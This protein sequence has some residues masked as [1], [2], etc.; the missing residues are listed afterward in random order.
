MKFNSLFF[1]GLNAM[2]ALGLLS[3]LFTCSP[4][5]DTR[6]TRILVFTKT[7]GFRH[8][9][10][11][12]GV[13]A[14]KKLGQENGF[15]AVH[16]E[17]SKYFN[18]DFLKTIS[19][20]MFLNTTGD[21]LDPA[22]K[23]A[24]Q[25]YIQA[26]GGFVGV[27]SA[28][29]TEYNWKWYGDMVGAYFL[30]HPE[31]Q[32]ARVIVEDREHISTKMLPEVW[33]R[34]D[35]WYDFKEVRF[36]LNRLLSLDESS[37]KGGKMGDD[38]PLAW[39]HEFDGGR[40]W[41]TAMGHTDETFSEPLFL[42][43]LLGGIRYAIGE[44]K[45]DYSKASAESYPDQ[46]RFVKTELAANLNEPMELDMLPDGRILFVERKGA[47]KMYD[48]A[49]EYL[50]TV[51][52]LRVFSGLEDGLLGIAIDPHYRENH[53]IY[54]MYSDPE[55]SVQNV[56]RFVFRDDT[57]H[58]ASEKVLL[59]V[60]TQRDEC[61]HSGGSLEFGPDGTLYISTGDNTNPFA[62]EGFSP[63]DERPGR[64]PWD[65]QRSSAN[66]NDLRGKILRIKPEADGTYS[67]PEGNLFEPGMPGARPEIFVMGCRNPF[68]ISVDQ[69]RGW[70]F[71]GDV[72]PD[73]GEDGP[74]RG[75]KGIDEINLAQG[76]GFWGWPYTRGDNQAYYA[77][78][79]AARRSGGKFDPRRLYN[80]S[81]FNTGM[82]ELP[83][84]QPSLIWY[85][86]GESKEFPWVGTGGKNPMAGP[87]YYADQ[88]PAATRF[89]DYYDGKVFVYEWMRHWIFALTLDEEGGLAKADP[90]MSQA[91]FS[92]PMD[93]I[94]G[95]DGR[96]YLLEYGD[97]WFQQ[98]LDARLTRIDYVRG[99]RPPAARLI[100]DA[101]VGA[102][103]MRVSFSAAGSV[104]PDGDRVRYEWWVGGNKQKAAG[105]E[106][107]HIF[108]YPGI[109]TVKV[110]VSDP[111]GA[112]QIASTEVQ[113][114]NAPPQ[115][116]WHIEGNQTFYWDRRAISYEVR[117]SDEED[118]DSRV[119]G[120][121]A[122]RVLVS[123]DYLARG[124]DITEIAQGHLTG[125]AASRVARGAKLIEASDCRNC[126]AVDRKINGPSYLEIADRYRADEQAVKQ[127]ARRVIKGGNGNWGETVM[128]AHPMLSEEQAEEMV[129]YILS[130]G[131]AAPA[132][133]TAP[134]RGVFIADHH[135]REGGEGM[136]ILMASYTDLGAGKISPI[137]GRAELILR[138]YRLK[139][140]DADIKSRGL[141]SREYEKEQF[142]TGAGE[143]A[144]FGFRQLDLTDIA[145]LRLRQV[146]PRPAA[147]GFVEARLKAPD[148]PL[149]G[150]AALESDLEGA[151]NIEIALEPTEGKHDLYFVFR[152]A[153]EGQAP[154]WGIAWIEFLPG[155]EQIALSAALR[156]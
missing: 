93:M 138:H 154:R 60:P 72:G 144:H 62:S 54:L 52:Q 57:L 45:R 40:A 123:F 78:D 125:L 68:R 3:L 155:E 116:A 98:N 9:S 74:E 48:P 117:V 16:T 149:L 6:E 112:Y 47:L 11:E 142:L 96:M 67:I 127:L 31:V 153:A 2:A 95:H 10:I 130:L 91:S 26:G 64:S 27:H 101:N 86:Y 119:P 18:E 7:T 33:E 83:L 76:P 147:G 135:L 12:A 133:K 85:G 128:S 61:C 42:Q 25:R 34:T 56:S 106:F 92:R 69:K 111:A 23:V 108:P 73:A 90:F 35:E 44:N 99:N 81:P 37:Y 1:F 145:R 65:A 59:R 24:F 113:V 21:V 51:T 94:F 19:A 70:L 36:G 89:P 148:G 107:E 105:A 143:G 156:R 30:S 131:Q 39:Y 71:W 63:I 41:Y 5:S 79:F 82:V 109:Y 124:F 129:K 46:S 102:A 49:K 137:T 139:A 14:V 104:D 132:E 146:S 28:T 140:I 4:S 97:S 103:P 134:L 55:T 20:V 38:H 75:P 141:N 87:V 126:H 115:V 29:D 84:A 136:Y 32:P 8:Q 77:Y 13:T 17:D 152:G 50:S 43:H 151:A 15:V 80:R 120:F 58:R 53:W 22:Q 118:G 100:A 150:V 114:G 121:D 110:K 66:T 88:Y 122:K